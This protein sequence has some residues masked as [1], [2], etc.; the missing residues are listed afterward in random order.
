M[1]AV[2]GARVQTDGLVVV[3]KPAGWTSHDVVAKLRRHLRA[4]PRRPR[5]HARPRRDRRAARRPRPGAPGCCASSRRAGRRTGATVVFGVATDTLDASGAVLDRRPMPRDARRRSSAA[6]ARVRRRHRAGAADGVGD[7][8]RRPAALRARPARA[9]RSSARRGRVRIDRLVVEEFDARRVPEA[10]IRVECSS[11]TYIRTL[12]ADLGAA[13]GGCAHLGRPAPPARRLVRASTRPARSTTIE[14]DPAA[15][16]LTPLDRAARPRTARR[17]RRAGPRRRA[18]RDVSRRRW[19]RRRRSAPGRSRSSPGPARCSPSTSGGARR[20]TPVGRARAGEASS[21]VTD[22]HATSP[23]STRPRRGA[24]VTIGAFDGVHLGHQ[25]VLRAR[26]RARRR[27]RPRRRAAHVRPSPG[28]G[29]AARVGAEAAHDAR[30]EARAAR[31]DRLRRRS[32]RAPVR[33]GAEQGAGRG[34]RRRG[35][36]RPCCG[37]RLVVVGA[38]FH[39]GYRRHGDV[40]LLQRMGAELG[41]EVL[42]LGLV[43]APRATPTAMPYS[44]TRIRAAARRRR[45]RAARPTPARPPARGARHGRARRP[46]RPRARAS[47]PRTW[48]CPSASASRPTA[49]TPG[50]FVGADGVERPAAISLGRRPTFYA[51]AGHAPARGVPARLRRRPLRPGRHGPVRRAPPRP[52]A[53]RERRRPDRPDGPRRRGRPAGFSAETGRSLDRRGSLAPG[54]TG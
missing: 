7:Q 43:A 45:R 5:G 46:A 4:A 47:R 21:I 36:R 20:V 28:R 42:G 17:R 32:V 53:L 40:A 2:A 13:L 9:R 54:R 33:R 11:G 23:T 1:P 16:V 49:S 35:A 51:D 12:A 31:R 39:F 15:A 27:A 26:A 37:A 34:L 24:V 18:R 52:G 10:T 50:T 6:I 14:A 22:R 38:D 8:G 48:R 44:S 25:A 30:P 29:R 19:P 41:F 3:D